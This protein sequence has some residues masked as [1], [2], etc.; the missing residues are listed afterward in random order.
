M[1]GGARCSER[2]R[3]VQAGPSRVGAGQGLGDGAGSESSP[4]LSSEQQGR[5]WAS[6]PC[7]F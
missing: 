5:S 6:S 4:W 3:W 2:C 7:G 1:P